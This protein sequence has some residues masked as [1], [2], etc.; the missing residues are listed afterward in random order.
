MR[1]TPA[2]AVAFLFASACADEPKKAMAP[3]APPLSRSVTTT[4][5]IGVQTSTV[6]LSYARDLALARAELK[7]KPSSER[8]QKRTAS[9][10]RLIQD[11]CH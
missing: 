8:A 7:D 3:T 4:S 5:A 9:L 10:D 6:C 1:A 2:L 11:A